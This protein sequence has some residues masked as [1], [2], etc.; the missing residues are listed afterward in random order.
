MLSLV[1]DHQWNRKHIFVKTLTLISKLFP[2]E[3]KQTPKKW[4]LFSPGVRGKLWYEKPFW[5]KPPVGWEGKGLLRGTLGWPFRSKPKNEA[6]YSTCHLLSVPGCDSADGTGG[7]VGTC[8]STCL[9]FYDPKGY[10][11][12]TGEAI[13]WLKFTLRYKWLINAFLRV[14][15]AGG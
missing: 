12:E 14:V 6:C 8:S 2:F 5:L 11:G 7:Q 4:L 15:L 3:T 10:C 13:L 9:G 1:T